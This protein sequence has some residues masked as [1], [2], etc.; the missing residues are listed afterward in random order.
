MLHMQSWNVQLTECV[1]RRKCSRVWG[2]LRAARG[3]PCMLSWLG[4]LHVFWKKDPASGFEPVQ[5]GFEFPLCDYKSRWKGT[6]GSTCAIDLDEDAS[7]GP[8]EEARK[9]KEWLILGDVGYIGRMD[10]GSNATGGP[11]CPVLADNQDGWMGSDAREGLS[12]R[13][14]A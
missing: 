6:I 13:T 7:G 14:G 12:A 1:S 4:A 11:V 10:C 3:C 8:L 2:L 5:L 9:Y